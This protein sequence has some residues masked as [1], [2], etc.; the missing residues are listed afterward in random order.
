MK[1]SPRGA[2][3]RKR[4]ESSASSGLFG[5]PQQPG[6]IL[7]AQ[8]APPSFPPSILRVTLGFGAA[9]TRQNNWWLRR[10]LTA[11]E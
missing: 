1:P 7:P 8:S 5:F 9:E 6:E 11:P 10:S 4:S 3:P 2:A